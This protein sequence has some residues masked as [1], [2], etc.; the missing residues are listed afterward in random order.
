MRHAAPRS[1]HPGL[2]A[3]RGRPEAPAL[4]ARSAAGAGGLESGR[5]REEDPGDWPP[6]EREQWGSGAPGESAGDALADDV[7]VAVLLRPGHQDG[8]P[9][10]PLPG[11]A[12]DI[13]LACTGLEPQ[14]LVCSYPEAPRAASDL[15][16]RA[17]TLR[18]RTGATHALIL[19][20]DDLPALAE[21]LSLRPDISAATLHEAL[22][23][24]QSGALASLII[25]TGH[26]GRAR[27][28]ALTGARGG[29]GTT[30]ILLLLA[31]AMAAAGR[32]VAIVDLDPA[33]GI[34]LMMGE[35]ARPGLRWRDLPEQESA[36]HP[37]RLAEALPRWSGI[38]FLTGDPRGGPV[39]APQVAAALAAVGACHDVVLVDLPRGAEPPPGAEV[40]IV[41]GCDVRS[42]EAAESIVARLGR[43]RQGREDGDRPA[44]EI[45]GQERAEGPRCLGLVLRRI[46]EDLS[47]EEITGLTG[48]KVLGRAPSDHSI[49]SRIARGDDPAR[50]RGPLRRAI[51]SLAAQLLEG[52]DAVLSRAPWEAEPEEG[53]S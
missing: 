8:A 19:V 28:I 35:G 7:V 45:L 23:A 2:P 53:R 22:D 52:D 27:V 50:S 21:S 11:W 13:V 51:R 24:P 5:P 44:A 37:E 10:E 15:V 36:Y 48:A 12:A 9:E 30:T 16:Q 47:P 4:G 32:G 6:G 17:R 49:A 38:R 39:S 20:P 41:M 43:G 29:L 18:R 42:A 14:A 26:P 46:G 25:A 40:V 31:R 34:D 33:G 1:T 3:L